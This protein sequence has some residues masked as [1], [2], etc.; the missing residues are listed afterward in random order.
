MK[1][2]LIVAGAPTDLSEKRIRE[3]LAGSPTVIAVDSGAHV[4][5]ALGALPTVVV[6]DL[7][8]ADPD[9]I[10]DLATAGVEISNAPVE[11]DETDLL[12]ALEWAEAHCVEELEVI[13]VTG[14]RIDHFLAAFGDLARHAHLRPTIRESDFDIYFLTPEARGE[15]RS[16]DA[17]DLSAIALLGEA[18]VSIGGCAYALDRDV[19]Q[20]LSGLGVSNIAREGACPSV[21]VHEGVVAVMVGR[22]A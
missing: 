18:A 7:D 20:P 11:K 8:S 9:V 21:V 1:K 4:V 10:A 2:A 13:G 5:H 3:L 19:L 14:G 22:F 17:Q 15:L 6:G 16:P 12:L